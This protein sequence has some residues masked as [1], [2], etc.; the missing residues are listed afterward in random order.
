MINPPIEKL[1]TQENVDSRYSL[2]I[3]AAKRARQISEG[4]PLLTDAKTDK[5]V[6]LAIHEI[7]EGRI[8][9][10]KKNANTII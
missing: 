10:V 9:I 7:A 3:A 2:V 6:S 4:A 8:C 5:E 1:L